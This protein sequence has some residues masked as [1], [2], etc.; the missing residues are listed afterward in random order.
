VEDKE[1]GK[2]KEKK[3]G[4]GKGKGKGREKED[5]YWALEDERPKTIISTVDE[6]GMQKENFP[7]PPHPPSRPP[8][9]PAFTPSPPILLFRSGSL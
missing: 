5:D 7:L 8:P 9:V 4:R 2:E 6:K 1:E 3:K